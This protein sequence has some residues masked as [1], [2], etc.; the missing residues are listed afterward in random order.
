MNNIFSNRSIN[1]TLIS[2]LFFIYLGSI[3][4]SVLGLENNGFLH[5][6]KFD[7][8]EIFSAAIFLLSIIIGLKDIRLYIVLMVFNILALPS[9][10]DNF[11]PSVLITAYTDSKQVYFPLI[12]HIDIYLVLG[13]I[14]YWDKKNGIS[15]DFKFVLHKLFFWLLLFLFI[16]IIGNIFKNNNIYDISLIL[17]HS[18]HLRY[19]LLLTLLFSNTSIIKHSKQVFIGGVVALSFLILESL[20]YSYVFHSFA[21]LTS[22]SLG[23]NVFANI[24]ASFC[25]YYLFLILRKHISLR[26]LL[27][28]L[29]II[30]AIVLTQTRSALILILVYFVFEITSYVFVLYKSKPKL[31][32]LFFMLPSLL[33][34]SFFWFTQSQ[35]L[36]LNNF[37]IEK[38]N[39]SGENLNKIFVL[40]QNDFN[41]SLILRLNHFQ[42]SLNMIQ[43]NP[44]IGIG[45]G[46][47]NRYKKQYGSTEIN[48]MDSH[49]DIL[50]TTSQY[51]LLTGLFLCFVI[52]FLPLFI[53]VKVKKDSIIL[54]NKMKYLFLIS[55]VM[56]FAGLTNTGL[57]KHQIFGF[58]SLIL[59][60]AIFNTNHSNFNK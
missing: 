14:K 37:K 50:A 27:L 40:E 6:S 17:S 33:F 24:L 20:L 11:V 53:F 1:I 4:V 32:Y 23:Y 56:T 59:V 48:L 41:A 44:I 51:G 28:V 55:F 45:P 3:V 26:Y 60:L 22:G 57:F 49:N 12:T 29:I 46:R 58:L 13:V 2:V 7:L 39:I 21:R 25:C 9:C 19:L 18:Y 36:S 10:V 30:S 34:I 35:R 38:I 42:T 54:N 15:L 5:K 16:S 43:H 52:Y 47:W 8:I 31:S